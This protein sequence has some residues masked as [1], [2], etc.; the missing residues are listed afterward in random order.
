MA[1]VKI[2]TGFMCGYCTRAKKLLNDKNID[3]TEINIFEEPE[4]KEEM[5]VLSNGRKTVPQIFI[6]KTHVGG[7]DDLNEL[8]NS[9]NLDT[10]LLNEGIK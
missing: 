9:G 2:Y 3:F 1:K 5:L 6:G 10:I 7:W 8:Q 4:K